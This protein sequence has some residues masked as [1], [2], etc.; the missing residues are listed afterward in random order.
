M[1]LFAD[2]IVNKQKFLNRATIIYTEVAKPAVK[3][4]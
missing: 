4:R 1:L 2:Q 3:N